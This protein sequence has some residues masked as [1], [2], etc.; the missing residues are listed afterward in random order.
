MIS[1]RFWSFILFPT[2]FSLL[3]ISRFPWRRVGRYLP[4]GYLRYA[5]PLLE[6]Q[7]KPHRSS[8][9][10]GESMKGVAYLPG[11]TWRYGVLL[12]SFAWIRLS[13]TSMTDCFGILE[14]IPADGRIVKPYHNNVLNGMSIRW[15]EENHLQKHCGKKIERF[16]CVCLLWLYKRLLKK[17]NIEGWSCVG[18]PRVGLY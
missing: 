1:L 13:P 15:E 18:C 17:K 6:F 5:S 10:L 8:N 11:E 12:G 7:W 9:C 4:S 16:F 3:S 14:L 2:W